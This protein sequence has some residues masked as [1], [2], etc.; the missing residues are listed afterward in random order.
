MFLCDFVSVLFAFIV[1][2]SVSLI[3]SQEI[4]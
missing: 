1:L 2:G 4:G 3:L